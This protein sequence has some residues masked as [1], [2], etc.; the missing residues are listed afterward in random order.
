LSVWWWC[1]ATSS[2]ARYALEVPNPDFTLQRP[3]SAT[4]GRLT[5]GY[6]HPLMPPYERIRLARFWG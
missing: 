6:M 2:P 1:A 4:S 5:L 3:F